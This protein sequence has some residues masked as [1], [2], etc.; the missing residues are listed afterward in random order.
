MSWKYLQPKVLRRNPARNSLVILQMSKFPNRVRVSYIIVIS[1]LLKKVIC[2]AMVHKC[3]VVTN[4]IS[5]FVDI[6]GWPKHYNKYLHRRIMKPA[7]SNCAD[8]EK[9]NVS[10][11]N[12][13]PMPR[14]CVTLQNMKPLI[15]MH[16]V[17]LRQQCQTLS[18]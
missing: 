7:M 5:E 4:I 9:L 2:L 18:C 6:S 1:K 17:G 8:H 12:K 13:V 16:V 15:A 10:P 11:H 3:S 14:N